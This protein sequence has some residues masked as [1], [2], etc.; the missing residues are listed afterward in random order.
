M[1]KLL[2]RRMSGV[3]LAHKKYGTYI[4]AIGQF[5]SEEWTIPERRMSGGIE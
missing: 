2:R 1:D 3:D 5:R 4:F